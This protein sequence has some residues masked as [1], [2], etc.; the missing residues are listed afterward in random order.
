LFLNLHPEI[1]GINQKLTQALARKPHIAVGFCKV[2][3]DFFETDPKTAF[4]SIYP[5]SIRRMYGARISDIQLLFIDGFSEAD[6]QKYETLKLSNLKSFITGFKNVPVAL[7]Y[8]PEIFALISLVVL[9]TFIMYQ[10]CLNRR[11]AK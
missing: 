4:E 2:P 10:I 5:A 7:E 1:G 8:I 3:C 6:D 11:K 9:Q